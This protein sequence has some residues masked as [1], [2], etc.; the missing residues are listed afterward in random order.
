MPRSASGHGTSTGSPVARGRRGVGLCPVV[1]A[2]PG[3]CQGA[4]SSGGE[5]AEL[6]MDAAV[7]LLAL[8]ARV[9]TER[10][11]LPQR[12]QPDRGFGDAELDEKLLDRL[13]AAFGQDTVVLGWSL[14][15]CIAL[16][17]HHPGVCQ[18]HEPRRLL[19]HAGGVRAQTRA[20]E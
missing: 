1:R 18:I 8:L 9:V 6:E 4:G 2:R 3:G 11:V 19:E 5:L 15:V 12:H 7:E 16:D 13:R 20:L 17:E 10:P 14:T